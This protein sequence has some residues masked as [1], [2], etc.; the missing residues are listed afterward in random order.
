MK[1]IIYFCAVV[2]CPS[3]NI[4]QTAEDC[5]TNWANMA[6]YEQARWVG[7]GSEDL[8]LPII[9][10]CQHNSFHPVDVD[11]RHCDRWCIGLK[12]CR[13]WSSSAQ[14]NE[15]NHNV[16][17]STWKL[18][19]L[20]ILHSHISYASRLQSCCFKKITLYAAYK[21]TTI[22]ISKTSKLKNSTYNTAACR[23]AET[24]KLPTKQQHAVMA[25]GFSKFEKDHVNCTHTN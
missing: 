25:S 22:Y 2:A 1:Y 15:Q 9:P 11:V 10:T 19:V 23:I 3:L 17:R 5:H 7:Q 16:K 8:F 13:I 21:P 24:S 6:L 4:L 12:E 14:P 20:A 18:K